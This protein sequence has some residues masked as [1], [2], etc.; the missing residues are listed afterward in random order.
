ML[1]VGLTG[2]IGSGKSTVACLLA[3]RG[4]VVIDADRIAREVV[5]PGGPAYQ[6]MI[7]RFGPEVVR[8]DQTLDRAVIAEKAF[9]TPEALADLN[10]ITH[11]AIRSVMAERIAEQAGTDKVVV[12]DI[13]L[14]AEGGP[15]AYGLSGVIVVDAPVEVA[16]RRL[17]DGRGLSDADARG[18]V[19]AQASRE[20]RR[21]LADVV[22][23]NAGSRDDL[24]RQV[25]EA[26]AWIE[27]LRSRSA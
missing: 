13:P 17:V 6:P 3:G 25:D 18:R 5:E 20:D 16:I 24:T 8:P 14:L 27:T 11:P 21:Q 7:D 2:G 1:L 12:V 23:D 4:A 10:D 22:I 26:W 15:S 19:A 9:A